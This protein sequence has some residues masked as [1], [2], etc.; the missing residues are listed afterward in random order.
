ML[1][2]PQTG[3]ASIPGVLNYSDQQLWIDGQ[4]AFYDF[5]L[6]EGMFSTISYGIAGSSAHG[7]ADRV[8]LTGG[9][10]SRLYGL[11]YTSARAPSGTGSCLQKNWNCGTTRVWELPVALN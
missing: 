11:V 4:E 2:N 7:N 5:Q 10:T 3:E 8:E 6:E 9:S 1:Y